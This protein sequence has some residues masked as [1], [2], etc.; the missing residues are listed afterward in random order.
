VT[1]FDPLGLLDFHALHFRT[2]D[3]DDIAVW[4]FD[5][6]FHDGRDVRKLPLVERK[7]LLMVLIMGAGDSRL[8]LSD[9]FDDGAK[10]LAAAERMGLEG[11]V[12][13]R[14]IGALVVGLLPERGLA[15]SRAV[16]VDAADHPLGRL[17]F[18]RPSMRLGALLG[19]RAQGC[20]DLP[21]KGRRLVQRAEGYRHTFVSGVETFADGAYTGATPG[22][23]VRAC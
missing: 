14:Q 3:D 2:A 10:L 19:L 5:L 7:E 13:K 4:A 23:L 1:A 18:E 8:R 11:V 17:R 6:L 22:R 12:S 15:A 20:Y 21:M 16:G 9:S